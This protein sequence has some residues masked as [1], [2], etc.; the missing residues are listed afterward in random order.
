VNGARVREQ[1]KR[2]GSSL[3]CLR[4]LAGSGHVAV[5]LPA[6]YAWHL[7]ETWDR[8]NQGVMAKPSISPL[9]PR[10]VNSIVELKLHYGL[11][12]LGTWRIVHVV[13]VLVEMVISRGGR[14][15]RPLV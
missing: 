2:V 12:W 9:V 14:G 15:A 8:V 7:V 3:D 6:S 11:K 1:L 10:P 5:R 13:S 4:Q